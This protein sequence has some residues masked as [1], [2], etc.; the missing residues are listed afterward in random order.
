M[1]Y[2]RIIAVVISAI[3]IFLL[4]SSY[5]TYKSR[6]D[7]VKADTKTI[8]YTQDELGEKEGVV[9]PKNEKS[10]SLSRKTVEES[11][12]NAD[13]QV[14]NLLLN[15]LDAGEKVQLLIVG[16]D[17]MEEGAP[18]YATLLTNALTDTYGDFI[19]TTVAPFDGTSKQ[20]IDENMEEINWEKGFDL[21]LLE[22][23]TLN[24]NGIVKIEEEQQHIK[25]INGKALE[26][27]SD[28]VLVLQPSYPI[29]NANFYLV[30]IDALKNFSSTNGYPYINHWSAW[31]DTTDP[32]LNS[33]LTEDKSPNSEGAKVWASSL[34]TY[35]TGR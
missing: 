1:R 31:P 29:Y 24:N 34:I 20:F 11:I 5:L 22:P 4:I 33:L 12:K 6:I 30:Q 27:V 15:R 9:S 26:E 28:A 16:S 21:V 17:A 7:N 19:E 2:G 13:E 8:H 23:F 32:A 18:G 14:Q 10:V 3:C 35:F 25:A